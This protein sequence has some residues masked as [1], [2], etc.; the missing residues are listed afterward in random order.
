MAR[1]RH[2]APNI[3]DTTD[4]PQSSPLG[5]SV[6]Q[7]VVEGFVGPS[8]ALP[9]ANGLELKLPIAQIDPSPLNPRKNFD[10]DKLQELAR[11]LEQDGLLQPIVVKRTVTTGG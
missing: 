9:P 5:A 11:S 2:S 8:S 6:E 3:A 1:P 4:A 7:G 10:P